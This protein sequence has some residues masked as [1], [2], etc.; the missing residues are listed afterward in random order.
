MLLCGAVHRRLWLQGE[1]KNACRTDVVA[2]VESV[3][4]HLLHRRATL[5]D[6][7]LRPSWQRIALCIMRDAKNSR[8]IQVGDRLVASLVCKAQQNL[9]RQTCRLLG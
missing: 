9:P 2:K 5:N 1:R 6:C 3:V 8:A 4:Q 7:Q